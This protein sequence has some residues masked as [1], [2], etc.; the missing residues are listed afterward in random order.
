M[1]PVKHHFHVS[2]LTTLSICTIDC[3]IYLSCEVLLC[4]LGTPSLH[5]L[6]QQGHLYPMMRSARIQNYCPYIVL[7]CPKIP[8]KLSQK[9]I[10]G[11][12]PNTQNKLPIQLNLFKCKLLWGSGNGLYLYLYLICICLP[13]LWDKSRKVYVLIDNILVKNDLLYG[14]LLVKIC[15]FT[16]YFSCVLY[17]S[18][19]KSTYTL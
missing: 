13:S 6:I 3:T 11:W 4:N 16:I 18:P 15:F 17:S 8:F 12:D 10:Q 19:W 7:N 14:T 9:S 2:F 5:Q 1:K